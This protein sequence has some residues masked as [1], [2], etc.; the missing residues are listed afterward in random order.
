[1]V[2]VM[3]LHWAVFFSVS[4]LTGLSQGFRVTDNDLQDL[5]ESDETGIELSKN[6]YAKMSRQFDNKRIIM[7]SE[8]SGF[9]LPPGF[10]ERPEL[11]KSSSSHLV[12]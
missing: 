4:C 2:K 11:G 3:L 9:D 12:G 1:M 7:G 6:N 5:S 10:D 8:W